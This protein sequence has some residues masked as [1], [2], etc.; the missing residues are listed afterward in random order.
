MQWIQFSIIANIVQKWVLTILE[1]KKKKKIIK[2]RNRWWLIFHSIKFLFIGRGG[3]MEGNWKTI[4]VWNKKQ[5]SLTKKE[6][7]EDWK[8]F[9]NI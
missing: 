8:A 4:F 7:E 9:P 5:F 6:E 2:I 1:D 3:W